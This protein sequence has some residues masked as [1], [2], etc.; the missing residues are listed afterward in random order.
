MT[1]TARTAFTR[2]YILTDR[3]NDNNLGTR[4][5]NLEDD[6]RNLRLDSDFDVIMYLRS[7]HELINRL[8]TRV[9]YIERMLIDPTRVGS[10][11]RMLD[12]E[13]K[14]QRTKLGGKKSRKSKKRKSK[15]H[16][17]KSR[18]SRKKRFCHKKSR[19]KR[20]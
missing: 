16:R 9:G 4:L 20:R 17:K 5:A 2:D 15:K 6:T 19:R 7:Q 18:K 12:P 14:R 10:N 3:P 13:N 11:E 8:D 1:Q